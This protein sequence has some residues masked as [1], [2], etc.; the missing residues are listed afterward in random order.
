MS[1]TDNT[2]SKRRG[3]GKG[4]NTL[5]SGAL[6]A[7]YAEDSLPV[8]TEGESPTQNSLLQ[9]LPVDKIERGPYQPRSNIEHDGIEHLAES[10]KAQGILQPIVVR[11]VG[12][13]RYEIIAGERRW[14]AAQLA[15]LD[16]VPAMV[17]TLSNESAMAIG[18][19]ENIQRED[20][21]PIDE[22]LA[23]KRLSD[24]F[25][26]THLQVAEAVGRSRSAVTNLLRVLSLNPDVQ[27]LIEQGAL[28]IGHARALL[29][30]RSQ[31]QSQIAKTIVARGLSVRETER[32]VTRLQE[33]SSD[34]VAVAKA[35]VGRMDPNIR[36]LEKDLAEKLGAPVAIRHTT[37]GKGTVVIRYNDVEELDG[38]L[39]HIK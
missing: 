28:D 16:R 22:A 20:L 18:L 10:I 6:G 23:L 32:L 4:L 34:G 11:S 3:L 27:V 26:L 31:M 24:E 7:S 39:A 25:Q 17:K 30:L 37:R 35:K 36:S 13:G 12:D 38:I 9:F 33:T 21:N 29:G 14:R 2:S 1:N 19:I 8:K 15:G 5:L